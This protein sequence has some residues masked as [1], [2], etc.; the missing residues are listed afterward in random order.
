MYHTKVD[1]TFLFLEYYWSDAL[2]KSHLNNGVL[3]EV[4]E[5]FACSTQTWTCT[6]NVTSSI[7]V[8]PFGLVCSKHPSFLG[9]HNVM[10]VLYRAHQG[11]GTVLSEALRCEI[12]DNSTDSWT[13]L[14]MFLNCVLQFQY[15][16]KHTLTPIEHFCS[17][18]MNHH[19]GLV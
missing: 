13:R 8:H 9:R 1:C 14:Y 12:A 7:C 11:F 10:L 3:W 5:E 15:G 18:G 16:K 4:W 6:Y 19:C 2:V 17:R